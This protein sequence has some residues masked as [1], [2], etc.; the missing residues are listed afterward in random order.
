MAGLVSNHESD[1]VVTSH[2]TDTT[3]GTEDHSFDHI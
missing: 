3:S 1:Y 2:L